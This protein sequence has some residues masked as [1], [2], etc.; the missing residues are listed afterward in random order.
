MGW[1]GPRG[2]CGCCNSLCDC[3]T[4]GTYSPGVGVP[5]IQVVVNLSSVSVAAIQV[6]SPPYELLHA[7]T[8]TGLT[9]LNGTHFFE[10]PGLGGGPCVDYAPTTPTGQSSSA[11]VAT[12]FDAHDRSG[13][14][15]VFSSTTSSSGLLNLGIS[16]V[17]TSGSP[18]DMFRVEISLF[19]NSFISVF[20]R[21]NLSCRANHIQADE[22]APFK[23]RVPGSTVDTGATDHDG[24]DGNVQARW[25]ASSGI[26]CS[27]GST[28]DPATF[29]LGTMNSTLVW[30]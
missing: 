25:R 2:D 9:A 26:L 13:C 15:Y 10:V 11:T 30:L 23:L 5:H 3:P 8:V 6:V 17:S 27:L 16:P 20:G 12:T 21:N 7:V 24:A 19:S 1:H 4:G 18:N 22:P 29:I 28:V 14:G